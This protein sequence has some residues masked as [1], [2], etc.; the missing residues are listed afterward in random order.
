[1]TSEIQAPQMRI[2]T[3][4][5]PDAVTINPHSS[6]GI[7][8]MRDVIPEGAVFVSAYDGYS[9]ATGI[10]QILFQSFQWYS[11]QFLQAWNVGTTAVTLPAETS[12]KVV[13]YMP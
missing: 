10:A 7:A 8:N 2:L 5:T 3:Y 4:S 1:M 11:N 9:N 6:I 12:I 13:Y